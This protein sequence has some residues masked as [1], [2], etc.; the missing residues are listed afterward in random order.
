MD[1]ST[2]VQKTP[3]PPSAEKAQMLCVLYEPL[4]LPLPSRLQRVR[5]CVQEA[6]LSQRARR[7]HVSPFTYPGTVLLQFTGVDRLVLN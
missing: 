3:R 4:R 5:N 2:A 6:Q 7:A 1:L